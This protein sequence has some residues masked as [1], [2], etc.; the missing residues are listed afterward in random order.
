MK[1]RNILLLL[2]ICAL[3][4]AAFFHADIAQIKRRNFVQTRRIPE[5]ACRS[6]RPVDVLIFLQQELRSQLRP[7]EPA[8]LVHPGLLPDLTAP[9]AFFAPPTDADPFGEQSE[10]WS[11][12]QP[13]PL[14]TL[15]CKNDTLLSVLRSMETQK[16]FRVQTRGETIVLMA[17]EQD[18]QHQPGHVR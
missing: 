2:V 12:N 17:H 4:F 15:D 13:L 9:E 10:I 7:N 8:F 14:V 6:A 1:T 5:L 16:V 11:S 18:S 3:A